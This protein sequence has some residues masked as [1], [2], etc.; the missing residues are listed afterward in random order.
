[1][2]DA[3]FLAELNADLDAHERDWFALKFGLV[4]ITTL[5]FIGRLYVP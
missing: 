4:L 3:E 1:M 2:T 5:L